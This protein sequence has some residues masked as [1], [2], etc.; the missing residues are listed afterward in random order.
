MKAHSHSGSCVAV[1]PLHST[2]D[3]LSVIKQLQAQNFSDEQLSIIARNTSATDTAHT[4][5]NAQRIFGRYRLKI[6][7]KD[8]WLELTDL[9]K[10]EVLVQL[11]EDGLLSVV[12]ALSSRTELANSEKKLVDDD[13]KLRKMLNLV[14]IPENSFDYYSSVL[15]NGK[16]VL[17]AVG[18]YNEIEHAAKLIEQS[19]MTDMSIHLLS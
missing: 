8:F 9:L 10:K 14:G 18:N 1:Y 17:I 19:Q 4:K 12:G 16:L 11:P 7:Q 15:K 3:V 6:R 13:T 2:L 5:T